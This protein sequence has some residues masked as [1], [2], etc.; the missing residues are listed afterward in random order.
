MIRAILNGIK[1][2]LETY[3]WSV[4][5]IV[6]G[7]DTMSAEKEAA[8]RIVTVSPLAPVRAPRAA[9][10][11]SVRITID[12]RVR[13]A[14]G[15]PELRE[16]DRADALEE[17]LRSVLVLTDDPAGGNHEFTGADSKE[18]PEYVGFDASFDLKIHV[19]LLKEV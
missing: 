13:R 14:N 5:E 6:D 19:N 15:A 18:G 17:V 2:R 11:L 9:A 7:R 3:G 8:I 1:E 16:F 4:G 10:P 12:G